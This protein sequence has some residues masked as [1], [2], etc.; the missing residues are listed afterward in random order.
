MSSAERQTPIPL[1]LTKLALPMFV[2]YSLIASVGIVDAYFIAQ[3]G[4]D[5]LAGF[6]FAFPVAMVS[7]ALFLGLG[8]GITSGVSRALGARHGARAQRL[9]LAGMVTIIASGALLLAAL[10]PLQLALLSAMGAKGDVLAFAT[11]YF[12]P[13][14]VATAVVTVAIAGSS[15]LR[16]MGETVS[17]AGIMLTAAAVNAI[18]DPL[19]IFGLGPMPA[20]GIAGA[21]WATLVGNAVAGIVTAILV[22]R[23]LRRLRRLEPKSPL[24]DRPSWGS[25]FA[26]V[27]RVGVPAMFGN[28]FGRASI[29]VVTMMVASFG[30]AAV[31]GYG[32]VTRIEFQVLMMPLAIGGGPE[33]L[34]GRNWGR[35]K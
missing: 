4:T 14:L 23:R 19:L 15:A 18:L 21:A 26:E 9:V 13:L 34:V 30:S 27:L 20:L 12:A 33:P 11:A 8:G 7:Q 10:T 31:A 3:L 6:A 2:G 25:C 32:V 1:Q 16:G 29:F 28:A 22:L 17:S 24:L 5:A 35:G